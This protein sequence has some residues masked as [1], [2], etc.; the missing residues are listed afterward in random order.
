MSVE[1]HISARAQVETQDIGEGTSIAAFAVVEAGARLGRNV[2]VHPH[3][4]IGSGVTV[5]DGA[6]I[7]HGAVVGK[8]PKG[9]GAMS[10]PPVFRQQLRVGRNSAVGPHAVLY[11]DVQIGADSLIGDGA[12]IREQSVVG[13]AT[14]VGRYVTVNYNTRIGSRVKIMDH[15]WLAGNMTIEDDVFI[16]GG[17]LTANDNQIG[18]HGYS[19]AHVVGPYVEQGAA[20]GVG[21]ILLP[22]VR[23]GRGAT[24]AAGAVV[25][26]AVPDGTVVFGTP[27]KP[28]HQGQG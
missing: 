4:F 24:V 20:V 13:D 17:V 28:R 1:H 21:A 7:W 23:V 25:T 12:S 16:S 3:A 10:R 22:G 11:Y 9:P 26:K 19:E 8:V 5:E 18:A 14:I 27:A 15:S 6:E 2:T